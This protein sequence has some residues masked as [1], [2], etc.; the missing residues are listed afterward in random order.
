MAG[1]ITHSWNGTVLT[2]T[3]DSGTSSADLQGTMGPRGPQGAA[4]IVVGGTVDLTGYATQAYVDQAVAGV[5]GGNVDLS[6]YYTKAQT[7]AAIQN[8]IADIEPGT[9]GGGGGSADLSNYYT[10]SEVDA[11]IP[12]TSG[13][14]TNNDVATA[15]SDKATTTYVDDKV[16]GLATESFVTNKIA[17][18]QL[19]GEGGTVDL[20]GYATKD[21]LNTYRKLDNNEF[22][23]MTVKDNNS[24][25][26]L[27]P[28]GIQ[29]TNGLW[30]GTDGTG[31]FTSVN[32][33]N[34]P[35]ATQEWVNTAISNAIAALDGDEVSY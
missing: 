31:N 29:S 12:D 23:D 10:K 3:S 26:Y 27:F 34:K 28:I 20:T 16:A 21:D 2:V 6:N 24:T 15:V 8:A 17:E 4:G 32:V 13:F 33:N 9:G 1:T 22:A 30:I 11:L 18:A 14:A 25:L 35:V 7:D 19:G 5:E